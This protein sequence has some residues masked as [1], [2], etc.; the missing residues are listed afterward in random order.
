[1]RRGLIGIHLYRLPDE[2]YGPF[3]LPFLI[4][5]D[6]QQVQGIGIRGYLDFCEEHRVA[7]L[8]LFRSPTAA[9]RVEDHIHAAIDMLAV[10]PG[11]G[12]AT[13]EEDLRR[14]PPGRFPYT[15]FYRVDEAAGE[16]HILRVIRASRVAGRLC[17]PTRPPLRGRSLSTR[18]LS[19]DRHL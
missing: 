9:Q 1:V 15:V 5:K 12:V 10:F 7:Y 6:S 17:F 19:H 4:L 13:D 16:V 3:G 18:R 11:L 14:L 2:L 8:N